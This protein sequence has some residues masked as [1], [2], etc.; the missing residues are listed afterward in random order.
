L[1][2]WYV[3]YSALNKCNLTVGAEQKLQSHAETQIKRRAP[4]IVKLA[5]SYNDTCD[6]MQEQITDNLAPRGAIMPQQ[7]QREGLFNLDVDDDIWQDVG[8]DDENDDQ[9][10]PPWLADDGYRSG[11]KHMLELDRCGEEEARLRRE[12]CAMQ[13]W[14]LEEW[15]CVTTALKLCGRRYTISTDC[16]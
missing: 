3:L 7:I 6:Q 14:M 10:P 2:K 13:E 16:L 4:G 8:L 9:Q 12:R 5:K 1:H 11:I 15:A